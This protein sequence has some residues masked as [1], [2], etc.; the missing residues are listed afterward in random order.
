MQRKRHTAENDKSNVAAR[1]K[2]SLRMETTSQEPA[3]LSLQGN[4]EALASALS[5]FFV[6][7][8]VVAESVSDTTGLTA[9][10][11]QFGDLEFVRTTVVDGPLVALRSPTLVA[12]S[13]ANVFFLGLLI[14]GQMTFTQNLHTSTLKDNDL[15]ILDSHAPYRIDVADKLDALWVRL[16]RHRVEGRLALASEV[17]A[18][19][20]SGTQGVSGITAQLLL[21]CWQEA[22]RVPHNEA[23]RVSN[24]LLDLVALSLVPSSRR[25]G[26][27]RD[28]FLRKIQNFID[29]NLSNPNLN[30]EGIAGAHG[31]SV[32]YLGK[33]FE[34]EGVTPA[35]WV[36]SRRLEL[37]RQRLESPEYDDVNIG[38]IALTCGFNDVST[39]NRA[40][41]RQYGATP[42]S[43][44]N[45]R[46]AGP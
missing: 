22:D 40:F 44:R 28:E 32:R 2:R 45:A 26:G 27:R 38:D 10:R 36:L 46:G 12:S 37:S 1:V 33:I 30:L 6:E 43:L 9:S 29:T 42:N 4:P 20:I 16:P 19:R 3:R 24:T 25:P 18:Q 17:L 11:R 39:F 31:I 41:K 8:E 14:E 5:G 23:L 35:R 15:A 34:A 13:S 21:S 7:L